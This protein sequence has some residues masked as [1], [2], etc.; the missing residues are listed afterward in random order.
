MF[1]SLLEAIYRSL[2]SVYNYSD[3]LKQYI[4]S[5][6]PTDVS[7]IERLTHEWHRDVNGRWMI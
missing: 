6:N 1:I 2:F 5:K 7:D 4:L 3:T